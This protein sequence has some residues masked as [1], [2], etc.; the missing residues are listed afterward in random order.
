MNYMA[1]LSRV[2]SH[3]MTLTGFFH[4]VIRRMPFAP[5]GPRE[6]KPYVVRYH[7]LKYLEEQ[8]P[9]H[10]TEISAT[11]SVKKNTL[12]ELMDRMVRDGLVLRGYDPGDRRRVTLR[13]TPAGRSA[14]KAFEKNM[15]AN[16]RQ[17]LETLNVED[18]RDLVQAIE[19]LIRIL[20]RHE[21]RSAKP[22]SR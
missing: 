7:I 13:V 19:S 18:R 9:R 10:P 20:E 21:R 8:G 15:M 16:I 14:V 17:Y 11:L 22:P 2:S 6:A 5:A 3:V 4:G 12:S 1:R